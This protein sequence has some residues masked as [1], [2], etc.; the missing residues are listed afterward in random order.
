MNTL[1]PVPPSLTP[2]SFVLSY[3]QRRPHGQ[4]PVHEDGGK[5]FIFQKDKPDK[6]LPLSVAKRHQRLLC[7]HL[8]G[9]FFVYDEL[10][11]GPCELDTWTGWV[12]NYYVFDR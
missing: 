11:S 9:S 8:Q 6:N 3:I 12:L 7:G 4:H 2:P 5:E 10:E 1:F